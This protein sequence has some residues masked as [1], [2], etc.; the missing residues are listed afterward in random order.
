MSF[1]IVK[2]MKDREDRERRLA[3]L[4]RLRDCAT[5]CVLVLL[6]V[7]LWAMVAA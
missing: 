2:A 6:N 3:P 1:D 7:Q 4:R 5:I